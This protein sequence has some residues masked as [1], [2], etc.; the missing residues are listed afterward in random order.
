M[1][2]NLVTAVNLKFLFQSTFYLV[3]INYI[4]FFIATVIHSNLSI[5]RPS[6]VVYKNVSI[7]N[8]PSS[9]CPF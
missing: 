3:K 1:K 8:I 6:N 5:I 9:V 2:A 4:L 7:K